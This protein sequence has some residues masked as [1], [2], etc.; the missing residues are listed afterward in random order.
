MKIHIEDTISQYETLLSLS[1]EQREDFFRYS[2]MKSF[3]DMWTTIHVPLKAKE[4]GGYD[5]RMATTML[6]YLDIHESEIIEHTLKSLK[7][8]NPLKTACD[9]LE[10]CVQFS[11]GGRLGVKAEELK[12]GMYLG[13]PEKLK[14][15]KGYCGFGGIP[16]Y[17]L[18]TICPNDYNI[19]RIPSLI[20]HEFHHNLRFSY[21]DWDHGNVTLGEYLVIEGLADSFAT[22]LYGEEYLGP[23][24]TSIIGEELEYSTHVVR[25]ALHLK[26]FAEVSS[27]MF[28][29][30]MARKEGYAPVGLSAGAGYAVGYH[31][32]QSFMEQNHVSILEATLLDGEEIIKGC[33]IF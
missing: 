20:A 16:G 6:G 9:T 12:F 10:R 13:D 4:P 2:M 14:N 7:A 31:A 1:H 17:V 23:W 11:N 26:G 22:E 32:V 21:F 8:L 33:G 15:V 19:P 25:E 24:V 27:Y 3:E 29:D 30:E 5:V 18:T 28:G